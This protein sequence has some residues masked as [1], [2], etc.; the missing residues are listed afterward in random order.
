M[1]EIFSTL[2]PLSEIQTGNHGVLE[3]MHAGRGLSSRLTSLGL[4]PGTDV[5]V[6]QNY[7]HGPMIINVRGTHVALSRGL[8]RHLLVKMEDSK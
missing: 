8:A 7:G 6:L 1:R 5:T 2:I 4:T 3:S